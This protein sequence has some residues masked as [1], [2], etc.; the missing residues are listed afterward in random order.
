MESDSSIFWHAFI[1]FFL[2]FSTYKSTSLSLSQNIYHYIYVVIGV[3]YRVLFLKNPTLLIRF[4]LK[5][6]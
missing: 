2:S 5:Q 6:F 4:S 3:F 1:V